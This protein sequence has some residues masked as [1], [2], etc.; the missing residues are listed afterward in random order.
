MSDKIAHE[1][2]KTIKDL[3]ENPRSFCAT[4]GKLCLQIKDKKR[5]KNKF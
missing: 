3:G 5:P 1:I 4:K 2:I